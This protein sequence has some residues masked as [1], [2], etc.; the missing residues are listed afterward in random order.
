MYSVGQLL[1]YDFG[2]T[3]DD[4]H[5]AEDE[6]IKK[7]EVR[8]YEEFNSLQA[9]MVHSLNEMSRLRKGSWKGMGEPGQKDEG[10]ENS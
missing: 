1:H 7:L 2:S 5:F 6:R 4:A 3:T 9:S 10:G 8:V